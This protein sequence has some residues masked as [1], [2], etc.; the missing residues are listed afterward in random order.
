MIDTRSHFLFLVLIERAV[1]VGGRIRA[2]FTGRLG[3]E[4]ME[5]L[6]PACIRPGI[7]HDST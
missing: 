5:G 4:V 1:V 7:T 6:G 2:L 3:K